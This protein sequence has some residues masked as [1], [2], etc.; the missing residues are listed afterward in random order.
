MPESGRVVTSVKEVVS[1]VR[2]T[3]SQGAEGKVLTSTAN[4]EAAA[5]A[6]AGEDTSRYDNY[7]TESYGNYET[8]YDES[9]ALP[10]VTR[11]VTISSSSMG[12]GAGVE[13]DL[14]SKVDL[15]TG[16]E[17]EKVI[18]TSGG[19]TM[20]RNKTSVSYH[21]RQKI[22]CWIKNKQICVNTGHTL[23]YFDTDSWVTQLGCWFIDAGLGQIRVRS[24]D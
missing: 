19:V 14:G 20:T 22:K 1:S 7:D 4:A 5:A 9:T 6:G 8:Y 12:T 18:T 17:I 11:R 15:G 21:H 24:E 2:E 3:A 23:G 13:L 10:D 16:A